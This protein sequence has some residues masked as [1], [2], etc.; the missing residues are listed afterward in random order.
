M[1]TSSLGEIGVLV[2]VHAADVPVALIGQQS[3]AFEFGSAPPL[4][5][6]VA[7]CPAKLSVCLEWP[8][9][10]DESQVPQNGKYYYDLTKDKQGEVSRSY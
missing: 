4:D 6:S 1:Y 10:K 8:W 2:Q 9:D 5:T 3:C 7:A